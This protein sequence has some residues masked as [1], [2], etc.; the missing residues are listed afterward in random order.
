VK[1]SSQRQLGLNEEEGPNNIARECCRKERLTQR[2]GKN[3]ENPSNSLPQYGHCFLSLQSGL[4]SYWTRG[5]KTASHCVQTRIFCWTE[6]RKL[7]PNISQGLF[8]EAA[9]ICGQG[10]GSW[11]LFL[12]VREERRTRAQ[13][14]CDRRRS[15]KRRLPNLVEMRLPGPVPSP[16]TRVAFSPTD[17]DQFESQIL[18]LARPTTAPCYTAIAGRICKI[19]HQPL[20]CSLSAP[21]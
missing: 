14:A 12:C 10:G 11:D 21:S 18:H 15:P 7:C 19:C 1:V 6:R 13:M 2:Y 3:A 16:K 4:D 20:H 8:C 5:E 9:V 17:A